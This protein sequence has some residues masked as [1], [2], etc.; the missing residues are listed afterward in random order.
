MEEKV[1]KKWSICIC[2]KNV[3]KSEGGDEWRFWFVL[4]YK[5]QSE[6][7]NSFH[8]TTTKRR[9]ITTMLFTESA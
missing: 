9:Y 3:Q 4:N 5:F 6:F 2:L 7:L 1:N 8:L